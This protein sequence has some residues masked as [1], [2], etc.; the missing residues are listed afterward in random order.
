MGRCESLRVRFATRTT[1][2]HPQRAPI[3]R[4]G[5][6]SGQLGARRLERGDSGSL[7]ETS[8]VEG[9]I[10]PWRACGWDAHVRTRREEGQPPCGVDGLC[11]EVAVGSEVGD[12]SRPLTSPATRGRKVTRATFLEEKLSRETVRRV[13]RCARL[14][15]VGKGAKR[16][17]EGRGRRGDGRRSPTN[18][19]RAQDREDRE[20]TVRR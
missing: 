20:S 9:W 4:R 2:D 16:E 8:R 5:E 6:R 18:P 14:R 19:A 7:L 17:G 1:S 12:E 10:W 3:T 15:K 13:A 11:A